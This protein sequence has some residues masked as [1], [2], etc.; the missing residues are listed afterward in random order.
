MAI[1]LMLLGALPALAAP[2]LRIASTNLCADQL[3]L[4]LVPRERIT[5]L[6]YW[7]VRPESALA[8]LAEGLPL[9]HGLVEEVLPQRPDLI[10]VGRYNDVA[11]V[12]ALRRV[13]QAVAIV[14][15]PASLA[16][17]AELITEVGKQ[18]GSEARAAALR[19]DFEARLDRIAAVTD[20]QRP[21][22][23]IYT[24]NGISPGRNTVLSEV[25]ERAGLRNLAAELGVEGFGELSLETLLSADPDLLIIEGERSEAA[26]SLAHRQ[27]QHPALTALHQRL[28]VVYLP[29]RFTQCVGPATLEAIE[30]LVRV[31][32]Q[33]LAGGTPS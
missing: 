24:P 27:L 25:V 1:A 20:P 29:A 12:N 30:L 19:S 10:L 16:G 7:A 14:E 32:R 11:L 21:L 31:R 8:E 22:A 17:A 4:R 6:S 18:V 2:T 26:D 13:G 33:L 3:L 9:N 23:V 5:S 28:P 15:V